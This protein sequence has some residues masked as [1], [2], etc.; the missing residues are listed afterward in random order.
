VR[1]VIAGDLL[2]IGGKVTFAARARA[3]NVTTRAR[4]RGAEAGGG[5][6]SARVTE[7]AAALTKN[8]H[9]VARVRVA[10]CVDHVTL[11]SGHEIRLSSVEVRTS[12]VLF[13]PRPS[14]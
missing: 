7:G 1:E 12:A 5:G 4:R 14:R 10:D 6:S 8:D 9:R 3:G 11:M 2:V 13:R